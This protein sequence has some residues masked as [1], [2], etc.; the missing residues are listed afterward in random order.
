[1]QKTINNKFKIDL[2]SAIQVLIVSGSVGLST[3]TVAGIEEVIVTAQKRSESVQDIPIAITA[4]SGDQL[5][6][7]DI[8]TLS[9]IQGRTPGLVVANFSVGQPEI[10]IRGIGTK[11]DGPAAS[12]STVVSVDDVYVA[13]RT[14]QIFDIFDLERIEVLRGPQGTLYGKNSIGG[15]IN[16]VTSKPTEELVARV[17]STFGNYGRSD[18]A[19]MVSGK[20]SDGLFGKVSFSKRTY[21]GHLKD[22]LP[23]SNNYGSH[24]GDHDNLAWRMQLLWQPSENSEVTFTYDGAD[25]SLG[26]TN[27]ENVGA[28]GV[29]DTDNATDP[30]YVNEVLGGKGDPWNVLADTEGFTERQ[31]DGFSMKVNLNFDWGTLTSITAYRESEF[32]WLEDSEGLPFVDEN[33]VDPVNGKTIAAPSGTGFGYMQDV[34]DLAYEETRQK[35]QEFRATSNGEGDIEWVAGIFYSEEDVERREQFDFLS[36]NTRNT[37]DAAGE[38]T[39]W[40]I[41]SQGGY[42]LTETFKVVLGA[43]YSVEEK[44][45]KA[46]S[47]VIGLP[48]LLQAYDEVNASDEWENATWRLAFSWDIANNIM[49]YGSVATGFKSGGFTGSPTTAVQAAT[50]FDSEK[51]T[52]YE[53]GVKSLFWDERVQLNITGFFTD[54]EDLQVTRFFKP[55]GSTAVIGEFITENAG[56]AEIMGVEA[57]FRVLVTENLDI[58]GSYAY[59]DS[60][61]VEFNGLTVPGQTPDAL[62]GTQLR[63]APE[64]SVNLYTKYTYNLANGSNL[65]FKLDYR[66]QDE[67]YYEPDNSQLSVIPTYRVWDGAVTFTSADQKWVVQGWMK[68][69]REEEYRTHIYTHSNGAQAYALFGAPRTQGITVTYNY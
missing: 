21:D 5:R 4:F 28:I 27:R 46:S 9:D 68:N 51:A 65:A 1:M 56:K 40:A 44:D 25:D 16:F 34:H 32:D 6:E 19:G 14:A 41:Y 31:V 7:D 52:S 20:I 36:F 11:E 43:R 54:Y 35:T 23:T 66:M 63:Q 49:L 2:R 18:I 48:L 17:R 50:P 33:L 12:D 24:V 59:L 29:K 15:S 64:N 38:S 39:S 67:S 13:A 8:V 47:A 69:I 61:F 57:E 55:T 37:S 53:I 62:E 3:E 26:Q 45:F 58:G 10:A 22:I 60:E 30:D 42:N